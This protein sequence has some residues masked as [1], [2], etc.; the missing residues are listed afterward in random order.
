MISENNNNK[1]YNMKDDGSTIHIKYGRVGVTEQIGSYPSGKWDSIIKDKLKKG[2]QDVTHLFVKETKGSVK[3]ADI[4]DN[5]I[6]NLINRLQSLT[7]AN[8]KTFYNI[9]AELVTKKQCDEAQSIIDSLVALSTVD[10]IN[11]Y[12]LN[13]YTIIPRKMNNVKNY[14]LRSYDE[15]VYK[16]L[17]SKEQDLLD[18]MRSQVQQVELKNNNEDNSITLLDALGIEIN[19]TSIDESNMIKNKLGDCVDKYDSSF[20]V[21]NRK[22]RKR[23]EDHLKSASNKNCDLMWHGSR[24]CNFMSIL[25]NGLLI[26]PS[27]AVHTGSMFSDGIYSSPVA[28]KA[29]GYTDGRGSYWASGNS[30][31]AYMALFNF[32]FGKELVIDKHL[33]WCYNINSK[34]L[35]DKGD[36]DSVYAPAGADLRNPERIVYNVSQADINYLIKLKT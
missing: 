3:F 36:Y 15:N 18:N 1:Y 5:T 33:S 31:E 28:R 8:V 25:E 2:Y 27:N 26:R 16:Q 7:K 12:L 35:K 32:H 14:L 4:S 34:M 23:F 30:N 22:T 17:I 10:D 19:H 20:S 11:K 24:S 6:A 13:L 21:V 29:Y 9:G